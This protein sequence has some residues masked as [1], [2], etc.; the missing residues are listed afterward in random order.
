[1]A[2]YL[3]E[4]GFAWAPADVALDAG[5]VERIASGETSTGEVVAWIESRTTP[6]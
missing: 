4:N 1:M 3:K 6:A 2:Q 5:I